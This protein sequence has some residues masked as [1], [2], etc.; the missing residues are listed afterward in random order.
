MKALSVRAPWWWAILHGKPV[1]NRDWYTRVRGRVALHAV[2]GPLAA[3]PHRAID[4]ERWEDHG[5]P[6]F[7][8]RS[9]YATVNGRGAIYQQ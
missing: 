3:V 6:R 2:P 9:L 1:E 5:A 7:A 4:G 8:F